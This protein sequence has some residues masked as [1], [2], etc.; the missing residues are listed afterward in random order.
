[1]IRQVD[2]R[3]QLTI[4]ACRECAEVVPLAEWELLLAGGALVVPESV[5]AKAARGR[6]R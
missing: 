6:R 1:M 3:K 4:D 2:T 5:V